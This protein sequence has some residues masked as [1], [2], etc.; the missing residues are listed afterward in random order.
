VTSD[1]ITITVSSSI[2]TAVAERATTTTVLEPPNIIDLTTTKTTH[3][4]Q[5]QTQVV[6]TPTESLAALNLTSELPLPQTP[7]TPQPELQAQAPSTTSTKHQPLT[8]TLF[9]GPPAIGKTT[10]YTTHYAPHGY[11]H[12]NQDTLGT[13]LKCIAA[14]EAALKEGKSVVVDNT[15]RDKATRRHYV[16]LARRVGKESEEKVKR[17]EKVKKF[18]VNTDVETAKMPKVKVKCVLFTAPVELAVHNNLY[19][20]Y[21]APLPTGQVKVGLFL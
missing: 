19:R 6:Q 20:A 16:E 5:L 21:I 1:T 12:I 13:R 8:L 2:G 11:T 17:K 4:I 10:H 3:Q 14:V 9:V 18:E 15:N 7:A